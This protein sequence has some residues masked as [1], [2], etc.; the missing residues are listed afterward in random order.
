MIDRE[1]SV[2]QQ[3]IL[4][5]S[6][7]LVEACPGAGKT[8]AI[9]ARYRRQC[10]AGGSGVALLSFTNAA[11]DQA[12]QRASDDPSLLASPN[13]LGTFDS[14]L[15]RFIVTPWLRR[16]KAV[17]PKYLDSWDELPWTEIRHGTIGG[18]GLSLSSFSPNV[19]GD[20]EYAAEAPESDRTYVGTLSK[21]GLSP[22]QL[23]PIAKSKVQGFVSAGIFDCDHARV[24]ALSILRNLDAEWL[25]NRLGIRFKE[26][27]VDEFQ[28]C[29][30]IEHE[31]VRALENLGIHVLVVADPDQ[32]IYEFRR[33]SPAA[34]VEYKGKLPPDTIVRLNENYR[35]SA[36]ICGIVTTMRSIGRD[37]IIPKGN[38]LGR[39]VAPR[40]VVAIGSAGHQRRVFGQYMDALGIDWSSSMVLSSSRIG[41]SDLSGQPRTNERGSGNTGQLIRAL[42]VLRDS[43]T[44]SLRKEAMARLSAL[45]MVA[46]DWGDK[47]KGA[48]FRERLEVL[49][50]EPAHL[51]LLIREM[52]RVSSSWTDR[53]HPKISIIQLLTARFPNPLVPF[54]ALGRRYVVATPEDWDFWITPPAT[55]L[56]LNG[57]HI[58]AV[59]GAEFEAVMLD[60]PLRKRPK[61]AHVLD[62]WESSTV[63]EALRVLYVGA[64]RARRLLVLAVP[65]SRSDQTL[66]ILA[67]NGI[68]LEIH[69]DPSC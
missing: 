24:Q 6:V 58:H 33:A 16:T 13:F 37:E 53:S 23:I 40:V 44:T 18:A 46:F 3:R 57:L 28:D 69:R 38:F 14:F 34:F 25:T 55:D 19:D 8:R 1:L 2:M 39:P 66:R 11:V 7:R 68:E 27:I 21:A 63:S 36:A 31:I 49:G 15:H 62:D 51:N 45:I 61:K 32:S 30:L 12:H 64:S 10:G 17:T 54:V 26:I 47:H 43:R 56:A 50:L 52:I 35:S 48:G 22:S 41:A 4:E 60:I 29:S 65:P 20:L 5:P 59:K 67:A 9:V 42:A